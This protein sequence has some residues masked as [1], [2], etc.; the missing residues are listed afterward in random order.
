VHD[1]DDDDGDD[2]D[3]DDG[4]HYYSYCYLVQSCLYYC[5]TVAGGLVSGLSVL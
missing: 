5:D 1:D 2:D 3:D 4:G